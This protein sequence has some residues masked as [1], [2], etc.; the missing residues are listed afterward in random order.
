[1]KRTCL[2]LA[3]LL[4]ALPL[5]GCGT[6]GNLAS[7]SPSPYGGVGKDID[8]FTTPPPDQKDKRDPRLIFLLAPDL[9]LSLLADTLTLPY[10]CSR[11]EDK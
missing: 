8:W 9:A 3:V 1:M 11:Y 10:V 4:S 5:A 2:A 7:D 6:I